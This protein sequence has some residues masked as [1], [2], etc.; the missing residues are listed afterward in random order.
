MGNERP[1]SDQR[2]ASRSRAACMY[3]HSLSSWLDS[4]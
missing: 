4:R 1:H 2:M 3:K